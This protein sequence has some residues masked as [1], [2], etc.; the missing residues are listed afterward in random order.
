VFGYLTTRDD[1]LGSATRIVGSAG[2]QILRKLTDK[3]KKYEVRSVT[4]Q[5][6]GVMFT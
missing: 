3:E 5:H 1:V 4:Q 2:V 6:S